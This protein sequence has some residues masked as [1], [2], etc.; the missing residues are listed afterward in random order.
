MHLRTVGTHAN[1]CAAHRFEVFHKITQVFGHASHQLE[2]LSFDDDLFLVGTNPQ[3]AAEGIHS[4]GHTPAAASE[5]LAR[6]GLGEADFSIADPFGTVFHIRPDF[7]HLPAGNLFIFFLQDNIDDCL[8][9]LNVGN[10]ILNLG[11]FSKTRLQF[12]YH[13]VG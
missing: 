3:K 1:R 8:F 7:G 11:Q 9:F 13:Q 6:S 12:L 10:N 2:I 5:A 4:S